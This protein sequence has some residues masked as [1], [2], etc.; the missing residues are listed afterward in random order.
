M[1]TPARSAAS[2][3]AYP[4]WTRFLTRARN[5]LQSISFVNTGSARRTSSPNS[6]TSPEWPMATTTSSHSPGGTLCPRRIF[7]TRIGSET[8][9]SERSSSSASLTAAIFSDFLRSLTPSSLDT[10]SR[11]NSFMTDA[12]T[13]SPSGSSTLSEPRDHTVPPSLLKHLR[14]APSV[15][16]GRFA[17]CTDGRSIRTLSPSAEASTPPEDIFTSTSSFAT[18]G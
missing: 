11:R 9:A 12:G 14:T 18:P 8:T 10:S 4:E 7:T 2:H 15:S 17:F 6:G 5:R 13:K 3:L 1:R 16:S